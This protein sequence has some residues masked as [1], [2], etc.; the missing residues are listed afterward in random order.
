MDKNQVKIVENQPLRKK[1]MAPVME[2]ILMVLITCLPVIAMF[3]NNP[4]NWGLWEP[5]IGILLVMTFG[6]IFWLF[7]ACFQYNAI[8]RTLETFPENIT[9]PITSDLEEGIFTV[10]MKS[11]LWNAITSRAATTSVVTVNGKGYT[12]SKEIWG[13]YVEQEADSLVED[14][15]LDAK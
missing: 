8:L 7:K 12:I 15:L 11:S 3:T 13:I 10:V 6:L 4:K 14:I 2:Y 5:L 9:F 1:V